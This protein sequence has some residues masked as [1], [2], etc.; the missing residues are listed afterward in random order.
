[1]PGLQGLQ[2][3]N[4]DCTDQ[5][6]AS[7]TRQGKE[8][9]CRH[10]A[11]I[12]AKK[13]PTAGQLAELQSQSQSRQCCASMVDE[14]GYIL[15]PQRVACIS[16]GVLSEQSARQGFTRAETCNEAVYLPIAHGI[17][18]GHQPAE[19]TIQAVLLDQFMHLHKPLVALGCSVT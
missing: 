2:P 9:S 13:H 8:A 19:V 6:A 16:A 15:L 4:Q 3:I 11:G 17:V 18:L 14:Q 7:V 5:K 1:M 10:L 12:N